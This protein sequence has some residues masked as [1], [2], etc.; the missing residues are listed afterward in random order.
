MELDLW[1]KVIE[2]IKDDFRFNDDT[3]IYEMLQHI[4]KDVLIN[5]LP[6]D[7]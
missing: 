6:E 1:E 2:R 7:E 5:Y 3:A 4:P